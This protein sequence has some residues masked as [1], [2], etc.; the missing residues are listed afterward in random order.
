MRSA[1]SQAVSTILV[2]A[3]M[4]FQ[5][6]VQPLFAHSIDDVTKAL[7]ERRAGIQTLRC[8]AEGEE[9]FR[10][11]A[12][13]HVLND[14]FAEYPP[15]TKPPVPEK[16]Q[17]FPYAYG[18]LL[19]FPNHR[20]RVEVRMPIHIP[21]SISFQQSLQVRAFD[22]EVHRL[23]QPRDLK[24]S[25]PLNQ[26][27]DNQPQPFG[28]NSECAPLL[29]CGYLTPQLLPQN[30]RHGMVSAPADQLKIA[31]N[32]DV[33]GISTMVLRADVEAGSFY[34]EYWVDPS[35]EFRVVK[36]VRFTGGQ[37]HA[38]I[39]LVYADRTKDARLASFTQ[40][41][42]WEGKRTEVYS[43]KVRDWTVNPPVEKSN[44]V[45][46]RESQ[47]MLLSPEQKK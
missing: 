47:L 45:L 6:A 2:V 28:Y 24:A 33:G 34:D 30:V 46:T 15:G 38:S 20:A 1:I 18:C 12:F 10:A 42:F 23:L 36:W 22:G 17:T 14:G 35:A 37:Q 31:R 25:S 26:L 8:I 4:L 7:E 39:D 41:Q 13:D 21:K 44:F 9:T 40:T 43:V 27:F 29:A 11:G 3:G 32:E 19:D 16:D 5:P